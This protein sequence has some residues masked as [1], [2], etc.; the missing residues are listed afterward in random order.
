VAVHFGAQVRRSAGKEAAAA[1]DART[2]TQTP[3]QTGVPPTEPPTPGTGNTVLHSPELVVT[4]V[5]DCRASDRV[6]R[7]SMQ[8]L[9]VAGVPPCAWKR[10]CAVSERSSLAAAGVV[11]M[12]ARGAAVPQDMFYTP[13]SKAS[14]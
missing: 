7:C 3:Q 5:C 14:K 1:E 11:L 8:S 2:Q 10:L 13:P 9:R 4:K 6:W 12:R